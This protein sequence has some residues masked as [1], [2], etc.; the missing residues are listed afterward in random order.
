MAS[1]LRFDLP[2]RTCCCGKRILRS[3][4]G[5]SSTTWTPS[6]RQELQ[7][8]SWL[9]GFSCTGRRMLWCRSC[10]F[11]N[12]TWRPRRRSRATQS[13]V[14]T[15][16]EPWYCWPQWASRSSSWIQHRACS[17]R[18]RKRRSR[19][20]QKASR[21]SASRS[22]WLAT[23][24]LSSQVPWLSCVSGPAG[25][26]RSSQTRRQDLDLR[27]RLALLVESVS[28]LQLTPSCLCG[29]WLS[30]VCRRSCN[31]KGTRRF[32]Q[33]FPR[34]SVRCWKGCSKSLQRFSAKKYHKLCS[35]SSTA[36]RTKSCHLR[37]S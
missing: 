25:S 33:L 17:G 34:I 7:L 36:F 29:L 27:A 16:M 30:P 10:N 35:A 2:S 3:T 26:T 19:V 37:H 8:W 21:A 23:S 9:N 24:G 18:R 4:S 1:F 5:S 14:P 28:S 22:S 20:R 6:R 12:T 15:R 31:E 11:A 32:A 13:F